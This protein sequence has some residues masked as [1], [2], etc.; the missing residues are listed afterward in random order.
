[1][2]QKGRADVSRRSVTQQQTQGHFLKPKQKKYPRA[3]FRQDHASQDNCEINVLEI[4]F[5]KPKKFIFF[6]SMGLKRFVYL[7]ANQ[8]RVLALKDLEVQ[9]TLELLTCYLFLLSNLIQ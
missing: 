4:I 1:M 2:L 5:A 6:W 9:N 7:L 3:S 8:I